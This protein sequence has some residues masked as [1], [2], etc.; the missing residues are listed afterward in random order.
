M[1]FQNN[2]TETSPKKKLS[3]GEEDIRNE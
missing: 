1:K 2:T 3:Q